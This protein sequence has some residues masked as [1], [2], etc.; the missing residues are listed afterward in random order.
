[1]LIDAPTGDDNGG[2]QGHGE[3]EW[4]RQERGYKPDEQP[5][6]LFDLRH[7]LAEPRNLYADRPEIVQSLKSLLQKYIRDGRSTPGKPQ[8]NDVPVQTASKP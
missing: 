2:S 5:G 8:A 6:Q 1:M 4:F 7:D 3:P